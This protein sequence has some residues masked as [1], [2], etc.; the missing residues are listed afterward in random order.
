MRKIAEG[1]PWK[2]PATIDDPTVLQ[3]VTDAMRARGLGK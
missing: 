1:V 3:E 2:M